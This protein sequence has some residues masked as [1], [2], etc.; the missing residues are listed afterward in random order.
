MVLQYWRSFEHLEAY[1]RA[2]DAAHLP[3]WQAFNKA[4]GSNGDVGIWHETYIVS[5]G[6]YETFYNNMPP[7]GLGLAGSIEPAQGRMTSAK[8]R[9]GVSEATD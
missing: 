5:K 8:G 4:I 2:R 6:K 9:L 7:F 1:A 3:A